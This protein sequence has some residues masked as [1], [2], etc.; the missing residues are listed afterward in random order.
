[1]HRMQV[2]LEEAQYEALAH[3]AQATGRSI[4]A[5][6]RAAVDQAYGQ[7]SVDAF[8]AALDTSAGAWRGRD[9]DGASY[10]DTIRPGFGDRLARR[11]WE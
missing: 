9:T 11:G 7:R 5:L 8:V 10:V 3:R 2:L 6:V 1:M 4:G